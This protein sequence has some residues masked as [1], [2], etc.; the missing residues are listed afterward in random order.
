MDRQPN[1][2]LRHMRVFAAILQVGSLAGAAS[3]L[4]V[5]AAAVSKSL[6]ELETEIGVRLLERSKKGVKPTLAGE[7]FHEHITESLLS[8]NQAVASATETD[9]E[10]ERLSIG[11][12]PT[13]AGSVVPEALAQMYD[14][15]RRAN[16][17]V[18]TGHYEDLAAKLRS[19]EVDLIVGRIITRDTAGLSFEQLY[20]E[21]VVAVVSASHPLAS[22]G[23]SAPSEISGYPIIVTP[24]GSTV[25]QSV[26]DFFFATGIRPRSL[27]IET[28]GDGFARRHTMLTEAIWFTPAGL[29]EQDIENGTLARLPLEH[30]TL[31]TVIGLTTRTNEALSGASRQ[32]A[33]IVRGLAVTTR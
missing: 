31:H 2:R 30:A 8:L 11:A 19:R 3:A 27:L 16:I 23:L 5:T 10:R 26:D 15:T 20:E 17:K 33:D 4:H 22:S 7:R 24:T 6:R 18:M 12:L 29:A 1:V 25:R 9:V 21:S 14:S 28:L 32:F 13:A